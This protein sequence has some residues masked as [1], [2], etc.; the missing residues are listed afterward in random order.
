MFRIVYFH[1]KSSLK[2]TV[3]PIKSDSDVIFCLQLLS[4]TV[5]NLYMSLELMRIG[6]IHKWSI[7][8]KSLVICKQNMTSLSLLAG[9]TVHGYIICS[10]H[11]KQTTFEDR[12]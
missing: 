1:D 5:L 12:N 11:K 4:K 3:M 9:R 6:L 2:C 7:D 10:R 8:Y